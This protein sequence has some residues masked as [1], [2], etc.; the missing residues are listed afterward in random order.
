MSYLDDL[1]MNIETAEKYLACIEESAENHYLVSMGFC[2][3]SLRSTLKSIRHCIRCAKG[4]QA[5]LGPDKKFKCHGGCVRPG[6]FDDFAETNK[7]M[8]YMF[9]LTQRK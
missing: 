4:K 1:D 6:A 3:D 9:S 5:E 2:V 7:N 8:L